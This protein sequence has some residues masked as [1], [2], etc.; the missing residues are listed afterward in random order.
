[1]FQQESD[2]PV[3]GVSN[4]QQHPAGPGSCHEKHRQWFRE[5]K[6]DVSPSCLGLGSQIAASDK[7]PSLADGG[8]Q[9]PSPGSDRKQ[10]EVACNHCLQ[11]PLAQTCRFH[12]ASTV[13]RSTAS[14]TRKQGQLS[15]KDNFGSFQ[16]KRATFLP[17]QH[18]DDGV[19]P[20]WGLW[21]HILGV[22]LAGSAPS[23][24][25]TD[26]RSF[27]VDKTHVDGLPWC[28]QPVRLGVNSCGARRCFDLKVLKQLS[29]ERG[30]EREKDSV[31]G[32]AGRSQGSPPQ[33]Q[34]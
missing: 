7:T 3:D 22:G 20:P 12:Q 23:A 21:E 30:G 13:E 15:S 33:Q 14:D 25:A 31:L 29:T 27:P 28:Q 32:T 6:E 4:Q 8:T 17:R 1:M 16:G 11:P 5:K 19:A 34:L 10:T 18:G 9:R 26:P 24:Q 2:V